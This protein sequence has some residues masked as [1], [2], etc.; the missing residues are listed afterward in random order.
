MPSFAC[1]KC[2][3]VLKTSAA[4]P[5]GKQVKCPG[6]A[7]VFAVPAAAA[8]KAGIQANKPTPLARKS[9]AIAP[10]SK[11]DEPRRRRPDADDDDDTA[12]QTSRKAKAR[13]RV[14][15]DD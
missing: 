2:K 10:S 13:A 4:I 9:A 11:E 1:P 5:A 7:H 15:D 14:E 6:C 8:D 3:K 12:R